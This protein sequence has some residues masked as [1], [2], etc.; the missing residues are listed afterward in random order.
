MPL[1]ECPVCEW[2]PTWAPGIPPLDSGEPR[3]GVLEV[4]CPRCGTYLLAEPDPSVS[5]TPEERVAVSA[6]VKRLTLRGQPAP[7]LSLRPR[8]RRTQATTLDDVLAVTPRGITDVQHEALLTLAAMGS[9]GTLLELFPLPNGRQLNAP[10]AFTF[11]PQQFLFHLEQL[12][13]EGLLG[14]QADMDVHSLREAAA[15]VS[16][17]NVRVLLTRQ[18]W[19]R[20]ED[21]RRGTSEKPH[22]AFVAMWYDESMKAAYHKGFELAIQDAGYDPVQLAFVEHND[23][24]DDRIVAEIRRS[25]FV[26]A[27]FT[28]GRGGVYFEAG[29]ALGVG[30]AVIFTCRR[31]WFDRNGV[32]FDTEHRN[33]I[34]W[35]DPAE[36]REKL[37][38]RIEAT[39]PRVS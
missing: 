23:D 25:R 20:V 13:E 16:L 9:Y 32:H 24:I 34:L 22:Q 6:F 7:M 27:D 18:G 39:V 21:L 17:S 1:D 37:R 8:R 11:D 19:L 35:R 12:I 28:G 33:H 36:L 26:V 38:A 10:I 2:G 31:D 30:K 14:M 29:F 3:P 15:S 5:L 4:H